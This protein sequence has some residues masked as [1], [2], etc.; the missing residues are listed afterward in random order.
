MPAAVLT[1]ISPIAL[2]EAGWVAN[3]P[4][5]QFGEPGLTQVPVMWKPETASSAHGRVPA[6]SVGLR[7][8]CTPWS[9]I[10]SP[11]W[12]AVMLGS[13][14]VTFVL[15]A[16]MLTAHPVPATVIV[17]PETTV[18]KHDPLIGFVPVP[19]PLWTCM[20]RSSDLNFAASDVIWVVD[21]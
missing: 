21:G 15:V 10:V 1:A 3:T 12:G 20:P 7:A 5:I 14:T 4:L 13:P 2:L 17:L 18:M 19:T 11:S 16:V 8:S 6:M 9:S